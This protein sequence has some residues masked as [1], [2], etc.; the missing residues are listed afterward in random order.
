MTVTIA[1]HVHHRILIEPLTE[2]IEV[3]RQY[4]RDTKPPEE[5]ELRLRLLAELRGSLPDPVMRAAAA[6]VKAHEACRNARAAWRNADADRAKACAAWNKAYADWRKADAECRPA[7]AAWVNV[8]AD[9]AP[10]IEAIHAQE[11]PD[12]PWDGRTIFPEVSSDDD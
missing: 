8:L 12:C 11:C 1:W 6:Y 9:H 3:R 10:A 7:E 2:P 5:Q 4:I